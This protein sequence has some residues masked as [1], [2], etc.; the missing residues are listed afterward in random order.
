[1]RNS[2][3]ESGNPSRVG[4]TLHNYFR[5]FLPLKNTSCM[6][7]AVRTHIANPANPADFAASSCCI[8]LAPHSRVYQAW[9]APRCSSVDTAAPL[10]H[11]ATAH[12]MPML[13]QHFWVRPPAHSLRTYV[14]SV[15][16]LHGP[17]AAR[18]GSLH[19]SPL[20]AAAAVVC[21]DLGCPLRLSGAPRRQ[22][23]AVHVAP[24]AA[25]CFRAQHH[26]A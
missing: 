3:C 24:R 10:H 19:V 5:P 15:T 9:L 6:F 23:D 26:H 8:T 18:L 2:K 1:M 17:P 21:F 12:V 22:V 25:P 14:A 13:S 7:I 4:L 16:F 11:T 20:A